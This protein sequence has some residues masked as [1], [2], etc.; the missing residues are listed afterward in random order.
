MKISIIGSGAMG[1]LYGGYLSQKNEVYLLDVW[2]EHINAINSKGLTIDESD[3]SRKVFTPKAFTRAEDIGVSDLV[4]VFVKSIMTEAAMEANKAL[5]GKETI[6][7]TLQNGYGNGEDIMKFVPKEQIIIGTTGHGCTMKGPGHIFH[8]GQGPTHIGAMGGD[9]GSALKVAKVLEE[10][11]FETHV[12]DEVF[13]LVWSKLFVNIG[14][15]PV[16]A[17]LDAV[18]SCIVDNPYANKVARCLVEEAVAVANADGMSFDVDEVFE[19]VCT[20]ARKTGAN[21]SSMLQD[22]TRR[23]RTEVMKINGA[24]VKKAKEL[25]MEVPYNTMITDMICAL[26]ETF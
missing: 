26:E 17:L 24:I 5:I 15:N 22:V 3:S 13:R 9:Q 8:A 11:G 4:I 23:S 14:I 20:V 25:G 7:M 2:E 12:S 1:S 6:V 10:C 21:R 18:N 19:N 16:T